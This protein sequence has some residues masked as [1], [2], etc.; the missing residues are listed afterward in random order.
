MVIVT[1]MVGGAH[2]NVYAFTNMIDYLCQA[3]E[4]WHVDRQWVHCVPT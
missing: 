4:A 3:L 2:E 1:F